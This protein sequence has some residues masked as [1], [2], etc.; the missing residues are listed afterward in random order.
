MSPT[1][2]CLTEAAMDP[3]QSRLEVSIERLHSWWHWQDTG[4]QYLRPA[5]LLIENADGQ[6]IS[7]RQ[8]IQAVYSYALPLC[9]LLLRCTDTK[10]PLDQDRARFFFDMMTTGS[11]GEVPGQRGL[12]VNAVEG[13]TGDGEKCAWI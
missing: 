9:K 6:P 8:F 4:T 12:A 10:D 1:G 2:R 7:A 5:Q 13:P 11:E 3:S